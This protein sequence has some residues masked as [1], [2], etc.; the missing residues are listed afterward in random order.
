MIKD[1][2]IHTAHKSVTDDPSGGDRTDCCTEYCK[3]GATRFYLLSQEKTARW[4]DRF[5]LMRTTGV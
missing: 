1:G 5:E 4:K 3:C 2:H